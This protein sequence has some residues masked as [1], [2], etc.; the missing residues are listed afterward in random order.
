M[1]PFAFSHPPLAFETMP[2]VHDIPVD[3]I[4]DDHV[5]FQKV[6]NDAKAQNDENTNDSTQSEDDSS[7]STQASQ[8][9]QEVEQERKLEYYQN[10]VLETN[11]KLDK[12]T[13]QLKRATS[14]ETDLEVAC[15]DIEA[16][17]LFLQTHIQQRK[18]TWKLLP[19]KE[20]EFRARVEK[21]FM[22][23]LTNV[24]KR[25]QELNAQHLNAMFE[26]DQEIADLKEQLRQWDRIL[27]DTQV[28]YSS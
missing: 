1:L 11:K 25:M 18:K 9:S 21:E 4:L 13:L 2:P 20:Q 23:E 26:K 8:V 15:N 19:M 12:L 7:I 10:Q 16:Q 3:V 28:F 27:G 14:S 24:N 17:R 6:L 22:N 5:T